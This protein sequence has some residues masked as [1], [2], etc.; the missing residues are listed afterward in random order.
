M[1]IPAVKIIAFLVLGQIWAF[2]KGLCERKSFYEAI[3][4]IRILIN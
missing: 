3:N 1:C 4:F 2:F